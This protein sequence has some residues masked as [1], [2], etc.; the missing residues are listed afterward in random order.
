MTLDELIAVMARF[1]AAHGIRYFTFG[2]VS[3]SLWGRART[4]RDL[5]VVVCAERRN[6]PPLVAGLNKLG[7]RITKSIARKLMEGRIIKLPIGETELDVK[8]C[9]TNHDL[10]TLER[11]KVAKFEDFE[12]SVASPEDVVLYKLQT[13]RRQDQADI[14]NLLENVR[15]I[16]LGYVKSHLASLE[17]ATGYPMRQRWDDIRPR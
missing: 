4:T 14:E 13:W 1:F 10:E 2:G 8:L 15:D 17:E 11:S 5:D 12:L 7:L 16:D 3:V 6:I 9:S